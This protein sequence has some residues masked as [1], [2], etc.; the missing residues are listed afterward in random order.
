MSMNWLSFSLRTDSPGT[1]KL[2][3]DGLCLHTP[4]P[5]ALSTEGPSHDESWSEFC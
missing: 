4:S 3:T 2:R 5:D 1:D